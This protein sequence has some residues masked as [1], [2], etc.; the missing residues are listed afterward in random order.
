MDSGHESLQDAK[1][2]TGNLGRLVGGWVGV[3]GDQLVVQEALLTILNDFQYFSGYRSIMNMG[4]PAEGAEIM[5]PLALPANWTLV[6]YT[7]V[8]TLVD[9]QHA[10]R[11]LPPIWCYLKLLVG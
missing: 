11:Q 7:T 1:V 5:T 9:P 4:A 10:Q 6:F 8:S 2:V 3:E